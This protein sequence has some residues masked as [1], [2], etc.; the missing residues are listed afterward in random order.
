M[1]DRICKYSSYA[2]LVIYE[3][4]EISKFKQEIILVKLNPL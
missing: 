1:K 3:I 4:L 2:K